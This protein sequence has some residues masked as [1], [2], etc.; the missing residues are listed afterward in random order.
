ML[1]PG[2]LAVR[3]L[4]TRG[5][6]RGLVQRY[7]GPPDRLFPV[8]HWLNWSGKKAWGIEWVELTEMTS[9]FEAGFLRSARIRRLPKLQVEVVIDRIYRLREATPLKHQQ[10][11]EDWQRR[12]NACAS[13]AADLISEARRR[14][15]RTPHKC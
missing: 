3:D 7:L 4:V 1:D 5:W 13:A 10:I 11:E 15:Y 8:V 2:Y 14:G 9:G 6:T 12:I